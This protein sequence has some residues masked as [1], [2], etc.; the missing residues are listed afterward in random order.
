MTQEKSG[1]KSHL[2]LNCL[3]INPGSKHH[4]FRVYMKSNFAKGTNARR[5]L[6]KLTNSTYAKERTDQIP[7][8]KPSASLPTQLIYPP[9]PKQETPLLVL[10]HVLGSFTRV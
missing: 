9:W 7:Q 10:S 5:P 8:A 1:L 4:Q 2:V 3:I 6:G